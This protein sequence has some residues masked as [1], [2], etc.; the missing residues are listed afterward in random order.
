V[1]AA[2]L[3]AHVLLK[4][5]ATVVAAPDGRVRV[6][7]TGSPYL[8]SAGSGDVLAGVVGSLMAQGLDPLDAGSVGAYLHGR[9]GDIARSSAGALLDV[10]PLVLDELG[11]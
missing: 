11:H 3:G 10:W 6:N 9:A 2:D 4:G 1:L 8:A 7:G 5:D